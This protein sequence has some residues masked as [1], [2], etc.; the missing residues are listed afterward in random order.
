[1]QRLLQHLIC[2]ETAFMFHSAKPSPEHVKVI[3]HTGCKLLFR[4]KL[5][6]HLSFLQSNSFLTVPN[7]KAYILL[8]VL[9]I[10][11]ALAKNWK[12]KMTHHHSLEYQEVMKQHWGDLNLLTLHSYQGLDSS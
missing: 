4:Y 7:F 10:Y 1:M 9:A 8:K 3:K 6:Y 12:G 11:R 5:F 2:P